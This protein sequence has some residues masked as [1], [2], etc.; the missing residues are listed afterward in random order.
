MTRDVDMVM[1]RGRGLKMFFEPIFKI[2]GWLS[3]IFMIT[4]NPATFESVYDPTSF[5][6]WVFILGGHQEVFDGMT[7]FQMHFNAIFLTSSLVALAQPLML[8]YHYVFLVLCCCYWLAS[9]YLACSSFGLFGSWSS[10]YSMMPIL[11]ICI[12]L[13][14]SLNV[15]LHFPDNLVWSTLFLPCDTMFQ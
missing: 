11:G 5:K 1:Y 6:D 10:L 9:C 12:C 2:S 14:T 3:Y 13:M 7:S 4:V 15:F 8:R